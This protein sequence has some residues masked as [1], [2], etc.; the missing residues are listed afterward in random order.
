MLQE[1][2]EHPLCRALSL[3]ACHLRLPH[4]LEAPA[5]EIA[6]DTSASDDGVSS[7]HK[8]VCF[9]GFEMR[10]FL[11]DGFSFCYTRTIFKT[12]VVV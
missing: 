1:D 3:Y 9:S 12:R 8:M 7:F 11:F 10:S 2:L 5:G 6:S 4:L